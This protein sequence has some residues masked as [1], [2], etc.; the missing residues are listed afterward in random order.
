MMIEN[1]SGG[2]ESQR[3]ALSTRLKNDRVYHSE[4]DLTRYASLI[5]YRLPG[6]SSE[7]VYLSCL[8]SDAFYVALCDWLM[9]PDAPQ[10][11]PKWIENGQK[12]FRSYN[13][14]CISES[15]RRMGFRAPTVSES[16][17]IR[18]PRSRVLSKSRVST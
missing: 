9:N 8:R 11:P 1:F 4:D 3:M 5:R 10:A 14:F 13:D 12:I 16:R 6:T 18:G 7:T 15:V 2:V 17:V